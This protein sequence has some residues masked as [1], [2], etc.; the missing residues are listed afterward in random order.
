MKLPAETRIAAAI[1]VFVGLA[2]GGYFTMAAIANGNASSTSASDYVAL[3]TTVDKLVTVKINGKTVIKRI[4]VVKRIVAKPTTVLESVTLTTPG[5]TRVVTRPVTHLVPVVKKTVVTVNGKTKTISQVVTDV[6]AV[7][8]VVTNQ[9]TVTDQSTVEHSNTV[10]HTVTNTVTN[11][12]TA[13]PVTVVQENTVTV[14]ETVVQPPD[15]VTIVVTETEPPPG[16]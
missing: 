8:N 5:G 13:P 12:V 6:Q 7:T 9:R 4:P 14:T 10:T 1:V 16:P 2:V 3:E 15:T 11:V